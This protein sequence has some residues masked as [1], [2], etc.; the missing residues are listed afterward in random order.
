M[1]GR[2]HPAGAGG[3][4]S[5]RERVRDTPGCPDGT[6]HGGLTVDWVPDD[7]LEPIDPRVVRRK[8]DGLVRLTF[9]SHLRVVRCGDG[10]SVE[11][12]T[13]SKFVPGSRA[14]GVRRRGPAD[15]AAV[16][17]VLLHL[18]RGL[19]P[20]RGDGAGLDGRLQGFKRHGRDLLPREQ[21]RGPVPRVGRRGIRRPAPAR[22]GDAVL[23]ARDVGG[24][25]PGP[26]PLGP[27]RL[28]A[29]RRRRVGDRPRR[30]RHA[31][32]PGPRRLAGDLPRQPPHHPPGRG[33]QVLD[34]RAPARP[35]NPS[36]ILRRTP[37]RSS[38]RPPTSSATALSPTS[39]SRPG[40]SRPETRS[41]FTTARPT[42]ARRSSSSRRRS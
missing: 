39:Y 19:A 29:R 10:R 34:G 23:P 28:P 42:P 16:R 9:T 3:G 33:R 24:P 5:P 35:G 15:H 20:R 30:R 40:S 4:A 13:E 41:W 27:S 2:G 26:H 36:Q 17:P 14:G 6:N 31:A 12:V 38:S 8:A 11:E 7:Q 32:G 18:R 25:V 22:P 37:D 1:D 21:G